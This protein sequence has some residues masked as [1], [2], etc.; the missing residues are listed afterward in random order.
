MS[1]LLEYNPEA[2]LDENQANMEANTNTVASAERLL[3][4]FV[5][6]QLMAVKSRKMTTW[7]LLM[8]KSSLLIWI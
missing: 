2:S 4:L 1:A 8:V 7:E 5:I 6:Q 3:M